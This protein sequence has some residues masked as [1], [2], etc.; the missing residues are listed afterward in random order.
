MASVSLRDE[1][2]LADTV[3]ALKYGMTQITLVLPH[4]LPPPELAPDLVRALQAPGLAALLTRTSFHQVEQFDDSAR[5]LPH[6]LHLA[7]ALGL[8]ANGKPALAAAA[9]RGLKL[10][11][12]H[13]TWFIVNPAHIEIA[14][15]HLLMHDLRRLALSEA[16]SRALFD[17]ARPYFEEAGHTLLYGAPDTWFMRADA[18]SELDTSTFDAAVGMNLT[19]SM[20]TGTEARA[21][22]KLH[23]EVQMLWHA[24]PVNAGREARR[25]LPVN[26]FW[27]WGASAAARARAAAAP[28]LASFEGA[29]WL[30]AL[31]ERRLTDLRTLA[32]QS[33]EHLL[34]VC[35][36][37][38]AA[39]L[40]TD[41]GAWLAQMR[42][43]EQELFAPLLAA[44][45][46]RK[47]QRL[48]LVISHR[49]AQAQFTT[50]AMAQRKF[51]RSPTLDRLL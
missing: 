7:G 5:A 24:H 46:Q 38:S 15:S 9:M 37:L 18:W 36:N 22:R 28:V 27:P 3:F 12:Q 32:D 2:F 17:S 43:L 19:D 16:D 23:N 25:Q 41:W 35:D 13:G 8:A 29:A 20:P 42:R 14:R 26:A 33:A 30:D 11:P 40:A 48:H 1:Q 10:E 45:G 31:A 4:A 50:T 6:E 49:R 47:L 21:Y 39:A 34:L 44:L 51:W